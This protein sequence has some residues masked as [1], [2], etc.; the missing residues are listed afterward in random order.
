MH[1]AVSS[2][3]LNISKMPCYWLLKSEPDTHILKGATGQSFDVS[4]PWARLVTE[5]VGPFFG[6]RNFQA[7]NNL[8]DKLKLGDLC[9]FY[10]SSCKQPGIYGIAEVCRTAYP[11]PDAEDTHSPF[12][13][14]K[15]SKEAPR[16]FRIDLKPCSTCTL[17]RPVL[18][19]ELRA[20]AALCDSGMV[21][22]KQPRLSVQPVTEGQ[23]QTVLALATDKPAEPASAPGKSKASEAS[24]GTSGSKRKAE[25][26]AQEAAMVGA[27]AGQT[28]GT[29]RQKKKGRR[30]DTSAS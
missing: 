8:R 7:R 29:E 17:P 27:G 4:Y 25:G 16:W 24:T 11:D 13:D 26:S 19:P 28:E 23:W 9:F 30:V 5:G 12:Y 15:H 1:R 14:E 21:L 10:H 2:Y 20:C 22:L 3:L 6:V 18:L